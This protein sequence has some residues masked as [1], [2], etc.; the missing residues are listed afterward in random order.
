MCQ[1]DNEPYFET[2]WS[3]IFDLKH[4][5]IYRAEGDPRKK[6][7]IIDNRLYNMKYK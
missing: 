1:Y 5:V 6:E 7:F 2:I 3:S 4:F